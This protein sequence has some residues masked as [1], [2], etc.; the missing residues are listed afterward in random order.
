MSVTRI[1]TRYA[2]S[3]LDLSVER[4]EL[5][6]VAADI[7]TLQAALNNRD[8][9]LM[10]KSPIISNDKKNAILKALFGGKLSELTMAYLTLLV[11]KNRES[12]L[13]DIAAEFARQHKA[14]QNITS[15]KV[16]T[17][18]ELTEAVMAEI[19][20]KLAGSGVATDRL[21]VDSKIDPAIIGG[22]ILEFDNK[23]YDASVASKLG[24]LKQEFSKNLYVKEF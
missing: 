22:F 21:E 12:Y 2:K 11:N 20:Q 15:V 1:A 18:T 24:D 8:L 13:P 10:F 6:V 23:R 17:A 7:S 5:A 14:M 19:R 16:T 4:N 3:L 9:L